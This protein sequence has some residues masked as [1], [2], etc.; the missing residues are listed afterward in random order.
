L[1]RA[2]IRG[3]MEGFLHLDLAGFLRAGAIIAGLMITVAG[4]QA[5]SY[6]Q[7]IPAHRPPIRQ[8]KEVT[9]EIDQTSTAFE[10]EGII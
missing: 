3:L 8:D 7:R 1:P 9:S 2:I 4:Y 10:R 5:G 6:S